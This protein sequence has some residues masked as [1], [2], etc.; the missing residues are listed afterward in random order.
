MNIILSQYNSR[1]KLVKTLTEKSSLYRWDQNTFNFS[2][3]HVINKGSTVLYV[4]LRFSLYRTS[5]YCE[6]TV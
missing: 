2:L 3:Y 6:L 1:N 4:I 5:L